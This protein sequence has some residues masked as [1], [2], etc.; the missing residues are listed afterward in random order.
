M[1]LDSSLQLS[2][3][4]P[5]DTFT[6][7]CNVSGDRNG[8]TF[9]RVNG[10]SECALQHGSTSPTCNPSDAFTA[11]SRTGFGMIGATLF[12]S[13]LSG[14][15]SPTLNGTLVECFGPANNVDPGNR[16]GSNTLQIKGM[17]ILFYLQHW[18]CFL[19]CTTPCKI[20]NWP[21]LF[22]NCILVVHGTL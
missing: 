9:W 3:T 8:F 19:S 22:V 6:F 21:K 17:T 7:R 2:P 4:C 16:V 5:G 15:A 18:N 13:I 14:T 12:S 11:R 20:L 1:L 10:S